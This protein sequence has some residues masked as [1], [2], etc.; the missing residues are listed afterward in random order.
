[1]I[2]SIH[3]DDILE[4][5]LTFGIEAASQFFYI[6]PKRVR[7]VLYEFLKSMDGGLCDCEKS[8]KNGIGMMCFYCI[9]PR[10]RKYREY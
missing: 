9:P 3:D 10:S 2:T 6:S 4:I 1:M 8:S 7:K 5:A